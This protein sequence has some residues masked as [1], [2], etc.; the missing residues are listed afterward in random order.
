MTKTRVAGSSGQKFIDPGATVM[1]EYV[2]TL[3]LGFEWFVPFLF[4]KLLVSHL[5]DLEINNLPTQTI[6]HQ[7]NRRVIRAIFG[8]IIFF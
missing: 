7:C 4:I 6:T 3:T 5:R 8:Y 1:S 2:F